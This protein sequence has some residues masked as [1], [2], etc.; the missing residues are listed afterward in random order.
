M[1]NKIAVFKDKYG[2]ESHLGEYAEDWKEYTRI[3]EYVEV[4]FPELPPETVI[5][6]Q[7]AA[8]DAVI[9]EIKTKAM[10]EVEK[11]LQ[12][13]SELLALSHETESH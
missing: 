4:D 7:V 13:K 8:I 2:L 9:D 11:L 12:K 1:K 10:Q 3:T 5:A 6:N